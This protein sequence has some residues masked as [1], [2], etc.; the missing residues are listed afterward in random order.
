MASAGTANA[1]H[2][3]RYGLV[4]M[5]SNGIRFSISDISSPQ[6]R[7][8]SCLY[9]ERSSISLYDALHLPSPDAELLHFSN[10]TMVLV[11]ETLLKFKK[12]CEGYGVSHDCIQIFATEAMRI[13]KNRDQMLQTIS[14]TSGLTVS[15]LTA[16][17]ESLYGA[18]GARSCFDKMDGLFM[19]LGGGSLQLTYVNT[20]L[21]PGYE[22]AAAKAAQSIPYGA[23]R[24]T[25]A[26]EEQTTAALQ[27]ELQEKFKEA[28]ERIVETFDVLKS[29]IA[30]GDGVSLYLSGGGLRGYG[31]ML[32]HM[33]PIQPYPIPVVGGYI[34]SGVRFSQWREMLEA[35][36]QA[37]KIFGLSKRRR[38]Q[39]PAIALVV[40]SII[41][42]IPKIK[43]A[44][45]CSGGTREGVLFMKLPC[46]IRNSD[47]SVHNL[48][49]GQDQD[50]S[51]ISIVS[52]LLETILP[53]QC[54]SLFT[55]SFLKQVARCTWVSQGH[56]HNASY[57]LHT[58]TSG[59]FVSLPGITHEFS[60]AL[61]LTL[62]TRW[63]SRL[64]PTDVQIQR[65]LEEFVGLETAW[66]CQY[67][68][69]AA[70][71]LAELCPVFSIIPHVLV[72]S[73]S[74]EATFSK[75]LGK[76]RKKSGIQLRVTMPGKDCDLPGRDFGQLQGMWKKV[77][78][79]L[80]L[81]W[82]VEMEMVL[83]G[84]DEVI[85]ETIN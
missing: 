30:D 34:V 48:I 36:N 32:M 70:R 35:N 10:Q 9:R 43:S 25:L 71:F 77:G 49:T 29:K 55:L 39:F 5:G 23:A 68:G 42:T 38:K 21:G 66:M 27:K 12:I 50:P 7:L 31:S 8:L 47:P 60:A 33:D 81:D 26:L 6:G 76:K 20:T 53:S 16:E 69:T 67:V 45:F 17:E 64:R 3:D 46:S 13:A 79:G 1:N 54:P 59:D 52:R 41:E 84:S 2:G 24:L 74:C 61:A 65:N 14:R 44:I 58:C 4:D 80:S 78:K 73:L 63:G 57:F 28:Y 40:R 51:T 75:S 18:V 85:N 72:E 83:S 82:K 19:D 37:V 15:I 11:A 62:S 22:T 56:L